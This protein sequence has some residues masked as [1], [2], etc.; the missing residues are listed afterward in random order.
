MSLLDVIKKGNYLHI[1]NGD[2]VSGNIDSL[3]FNK[4]T[5]LSVILDITKKTKITISVRKNTS[6]RL[7]EVT[8]SLNDLLEIDVKLEENAHLE[9]ITLRKSSAPCDIFI[10]A[11]LSDNATLSTKSIALLQNKANVK[12]VSDILGSGASMNSLDV[13]LNTSGDVQK[14]DYLTNHLGN[15]SASTMRNFIINKNASIT[16]MNT[17]GFIKKGVKGVVISQK[18]KGLLLDNDS[19]ISANPLLTIDEFDCNASHGASIG[20]ISEDELYYLMSRGLS[21]SDSEKLIVSG[22][23]DPFLKAID[24][25]AIRDYIFNDISRIL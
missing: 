4:D 15:D 1:T 9:Y 12:I 11:G 17:N 3:N 8:N 7:L 20:A 5:N 14:F 18:N 2:K 24:D 13:I 25:E 21:R 10:N 6:V 22:F 16:H 19:E 23:V